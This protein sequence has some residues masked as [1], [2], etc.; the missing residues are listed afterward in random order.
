[1]T[2]QWSTKL[3]WRPETNF[4]NGIPPGLP[5]TKMTRLVLTQVRLH[6]TWGLPL[7]KKTKV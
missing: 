7:A 3:R 5:R 2:S 6:W 1:M 4:V